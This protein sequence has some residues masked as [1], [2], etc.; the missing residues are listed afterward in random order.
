M[1]SRPIAGEVEEQA[2]PAGSPSMLVSAW[3]SGD[4]GP[5]TLRST[6]LPFF[7]QT[8]PSLALAAL[9]TPRPAHVPFAHSGIWECRA[10]TLSLSSSLIGPFGCLESGGGCAGMGRAFTPA[11]FP[12]CKGTGRTLASPERTSGL[13]STPRGAEL[14]RAEASARGLSV[15]FP[16]RAQEALFHRPCL[17]TNASLLWAGTAAPS[18]F[19]F[20]LWSHPGC[21]WERRLGGC[22]GGIVGSGL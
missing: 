5:W 20:C 22:L 9:P 6:P 2:P 19:F 3:V 8:L 14:S 1:L 7:W 11:P 21:P 17:S 4:Y 16:G 15:R 18:H 10:Q 13:A 12:S